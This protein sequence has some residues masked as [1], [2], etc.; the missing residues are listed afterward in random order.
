MN[1]SNGKIV[2][3]LERIAKGQDALR[4]ELRQEMH[5]GF[6][7]LSAR[8][9]HVGVRVDHLSSRFDHMMKVLGRYHAGHGQR[10]KV[11]E[12]RVFKKFG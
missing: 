10:I 5:Q 2:E 7:Q 8:I 1:G 3:L 12:K 11:L 9:D 4:K 6:A